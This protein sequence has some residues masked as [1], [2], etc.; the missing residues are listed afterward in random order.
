MLARPAFRLIKASD[1]D[2]MQ[3]VQSGFEKKDLLQAA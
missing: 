3:I 1:A 2:R